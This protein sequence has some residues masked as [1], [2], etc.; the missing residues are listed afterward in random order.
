MVAY[1]QKYLD[2]EKDAPI[3]NYGAMHVYDNNEKL[4]NKIKS[5]NRQLLSPIIKGSDCVKYG[6]T[7]NEENYKQFRT[8]W[9]SRVTSSVSGDTVENLK[10]L[11][12]GKFYDLLPKGVV[13]DESTIEVISQFIVRKENIDKIFNE[14]HPDNLPLKYKIINNYKDSGRDLLIVDYYGGYINNEIK[15][16]N[17]ISVS[18]KYDTLYSWDS[19]KDYGPNLR[20]LVAYESGEAEIA[21]GL[22]DD[23]LEYTRRWDIVL[24]QWTELLKSSRYSDKEK[25]IMKDLNPDHDNPA[26][27]Y[28]ANNV[29]VSGNTIANTGLS[30]HVKGPQDIRY[31]TK[32]KVK[33][34]DFYSYRLRLASQLGTSTSN[35]I[36]YDTLEDYTLLKSDE[37]YGINTWK[38]SLE[39]IDIS[40]PLNKGID[41]VVYYSTVPNLKIRKPDPKSSV[42]VDQQENTVDLTDT[43]IWTKEKP[44]DLSKVTAIAVDL[45]K[46]KNGQPYVLKENESVVVNLHM[47]ALWN[48]KEHNID[49]KNKAINEIYANTTVT[50]NLDNKSENELINTAYTAVNLEPV[51]AEAPIKATKKYLDR[52]GK[53]IALK[54]DD[55]TFELKDSEGKILQ[56]KTNDKDGNITFDPIKYNPWDVGEHTYTIEEI[57][58][59]DNKIDYDNHV[60]TFKVNVERI[61]D[62]ELKATVVYDA[63]NSI[64]TNREKAT[65]SLQVVKLIDGT[66]KVELDPI[67]DND[68]NILSYKVSEKD[69]DKALD[70]A[71]YE[72]YKTSD[73]NRKNVIATIKTVN[74]ASNV[75]SDLEAGKYILKET[76]APKDYEINPNEIEINIE[77][78]DLSTIKI[79]FVNDKAKA[80]MPSTGILSAKFLIGGL[81]V[82]LLLIGLHLIRKKKFDLHR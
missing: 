23:P 27:L 66:N 48:M 78:N 74:G 5:S 73:S 18:L 29:I 4:V 80:N 45:T 50:T 65:A 42:P 16:K 62:L 3:D 56:T 59:N 33:E 44:A 12:S 6:R 52:D 37:D 19:F 1:A 41:A 72:L 9:T 17:T 30:K 63:D 81:N 61:G 34:G 60:E 68:G 79:A 49:I 32:T 22:K 75:V 39:S 76:K 26:F 43:S 31:T 15:N 77:E 69:K 21:S 7:K 47:K 64:F 20:N 25:Q 53:D 57:K 67:K 35:I 8:S 51:V 24:K 54:G 11:N 58:G 55:F 14:S 36:L 38:G 46:G 70:G 71:E 10:V 82:T 2:S 13:L 40:Q 28:D